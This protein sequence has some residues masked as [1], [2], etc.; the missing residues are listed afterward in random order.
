MTAIPVS[1][2]PPDAT[3]RL[4]LH[5]LCQWILLQSESHST[6]VVTNEALPDPQLSFDRFNVEPLSNVNEK[7]GTV[8]ISD[9][10]G[11]K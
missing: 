4:T 2:W 11:G 7:P 5:D 8:G 10:G 1:P 6:Y 3:N 9:G